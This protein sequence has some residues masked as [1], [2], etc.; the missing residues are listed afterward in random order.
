MRSRVAAR[1]VT[2]P[3]AFFVAGALDAGVAWGGWA[4]GA[5]AARLAR[6]TAR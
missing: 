1:L 6:R 5:L 2:G 3:L 4:A